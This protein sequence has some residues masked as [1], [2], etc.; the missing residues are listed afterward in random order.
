MRRT[1]LLL[2][3]PAAL[4]AGLITQLPAGAAD[5]AQDSA[6]QVYPFG[7]MSE[8]RKTAGLVPMQVQVY[9]GSET[10]LALDEL[11]VQTPAGVL[12]HRAP[13]GG[14][15]LSGDGG[16][17]LDLLWQLERADP[18]LS[19]RHHHRLF[20]QL[21]EHQ[22]LEPAA[23]ARLF[24]EIRDAVIALRESGAPQVRN[25][26]FEVPLADLFGPAALPGDQAAFDVI[27][28]YTQSGRTHETVYSHAVDLLPAY[29]PPPA[30]WY[31]GR[32]GRGG[33]D[34]FAGD[35]HVHNCRDQAV[36]GCPDCPAESVNI[37]GSFT[38]ADLK[39][40]YVALG[41]DWFS[42]STHS[43]CI[44]SDAEFNALVGESNTLDDPDFALLV[45]TEVTGRE[46]GP[47]QGSDGADALC[48]L[49]FGVTS[50]HHMGSH[51]ITT[52]KPG[53]RD[54]FLDLCDTPMQNMHDNTQ[55]TNSE[56][57]FSIVNHASASLWAWN[58][59]ADLRGIEAN[60]MWGVEIMNSSTSYVDWLVNRLREGRL[61]YGY[62]GSDTHDAAYDFPSNHALVDLPLNDANVTA[63]LRA[64]RNYV[65][66]GPFL[67]LELS[68]AAGRRAEMGSINV[69]PGNRIPNNYPIDVTVF[70]NAG[71]DTVDVHVY[72]GVRGGSETLLQTF[73]GV[74]GGG[75]L[76]VGDTVQKTGNSWYRVSL[77]ATAGG[78]V[79]HTCPIFIVPR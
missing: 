11:R 78:G 49:G 71:G 52:R 21:E 58:S 36:G 18:E 34:W 22:P 53:G 61:L 57:G 10:A 46:T 42:S 14:E 69:V 51:G 35:L 70:Y 60:E 3:L 6:L 8:V 1:L 25:L 48:L 59:A 37:T 4:G 47:Q 17:Y 5:R 39:A 20:I 38:N 75:Q 15:R 40:Q 67:T 28:R 62:S 66:N 65:S 27:V 29:Q 76:T 12:L 50:V 54:G 32:G 44:N 73:P 41:M 7:L 64:G 56:G 30:A 63:A 77:F 9:N 79:A 19:H 33:Q 13:L 31:A 23:E 43:Y 55:E 2:L 68:D 16:R 45:G 72:R 24:D 74:T 26:R